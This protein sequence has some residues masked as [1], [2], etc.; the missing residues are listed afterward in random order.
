MKIESLTK[1]DSYN[2]VT[3]TDGFHVYGVLITKVTNTVEFMKW[4]L[5]DDEPTIISEDSYPEQFIELK[6][7]YLPRLLDYIEKH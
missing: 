3:F 2:T 7:K 1:N 6:D 5:T 4:G